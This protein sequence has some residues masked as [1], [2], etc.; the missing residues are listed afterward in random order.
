[1]AQADRKS[2]VSLDLPI[3]MT[4]D[5]AEVNEYQFTHGHISPVVTKTVTE[6]DEGRDVWWKVGGRARLRTAEKAL[7]QLIA[8]TGGFRFYS[9]FDEG[10]SGTFIR[11]LLRNSKSSCDIVA[12]PASDWVN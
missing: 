9:F 4:K 2:S 1:M 5:S 7:S 10:D 6:L 11:V 8:V 12:F 3:G